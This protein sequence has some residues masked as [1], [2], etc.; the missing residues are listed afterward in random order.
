MSARISFEFFGE[1]ANSCE[2][3]FPM[4]TLTISYHDPHVD[5]TVF[6]YVDKIS[7]SGG[8]I[9]LEFKPLPGWPAGSG[10]VLEAATIKEMKI[11]NEWAELRSHINS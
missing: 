6:S 8:L 1:V 11:E 10:A 3:G 2:R 7:W 9:L 4:S 5:P